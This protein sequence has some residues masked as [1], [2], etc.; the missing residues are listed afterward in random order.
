M[1]VVFSR[2]IW[3]AIKQNV[4]GRQKI[5]DKSHTCS[6]YNGLLL[7]FLVLLQ[8][9]ARVSRCKSRPVYCLLLSKV[10]NAIFMREHECASLKTINEILHHHHPS[11]GGLPP[12]PLRRCLNT[13]VFPHSK[14]ILIKSHATSSLPLLSGSNGPPHTSYES[15]FI[16]LRSRVIVR[17]QQFS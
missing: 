4:R 8:A 9:S 14:F 17:L 6:F 3:P 13:L 12:F 1:C 10:Q 11:H 16:T 7:S 15:I 2:P 5:S